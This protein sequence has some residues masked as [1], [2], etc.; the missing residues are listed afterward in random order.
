MSYDNE[1]HLTNGCQWLSID[2]V[3]QALYVCIVFLYIYLQAVAGVMLGVMLEVILDDSP[4]MI[5]AF[6]P[7]TSLSTYK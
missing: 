1:R 6:M 2:P 5:D 4:Q 7:M 3:G